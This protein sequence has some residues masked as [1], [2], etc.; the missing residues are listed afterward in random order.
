MDMS[1]FLT[2]I[3]TFFTQSITWLGDVLDVI[4]SNPALLVLCIAM[5]IVGFAV[6]LLSRLIRL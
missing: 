6:G 2:E 3:G 5:P 1:A 4:V